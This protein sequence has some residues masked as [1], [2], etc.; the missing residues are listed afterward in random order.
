[1]DDGDDLPMEYTITHP[2][3][4]QEAAL[5]E[6]VVPKNIAWLSEDNT[7]RGRLTDCETGLD[8]LTDAGIGEWPWFYDTVK[9]AIEFGKEPP[10]YATEALLTCA[11]IDAA[12]QSFTTG[13]RVT[14]LL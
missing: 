3:D 1:M 12:M 14:P 10:V 7:A 11:V 6:G 9:N 2:V 5:R 8:S 4:P 13:A